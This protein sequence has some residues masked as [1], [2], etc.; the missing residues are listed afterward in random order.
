MQPYGNP[1]KAHCRPEVIPVGIA[2]IDWHRFVAPLENMPL[3]STGTVPALA[4]N[5]EQPLHARHQIR[6]RCF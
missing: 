3:S 6:L 4:E 2:A 5:S 1:F